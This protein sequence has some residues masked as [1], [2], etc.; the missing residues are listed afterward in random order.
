MQRVFVVDKNRK[1]LMPC[2]SARARTLLKQG[3]A[4][5]LRRYPFTII[6]IEREEGEIQ[7]IQMK[8]DTGAKTTGIALVAVF[9]RGLRCIWAAELEHRGFAVREK[10][11]QRRQI[12]RSRRQRKSR[13]RPSRFL[14]RRRSKGWLAPSL[15]SRLQNVET[16]LKRLASFSPISA[17]VLELTKFDTQLLQNPEISGIV[18]Q[19]GELAGYE[20]REYLLLKWEHHCAYCGIND[21]PLEI[22]HIVPKSRGG[23]NRISNLTLACHNCNQKKGNRT[24]SEFGYPIVHTYASKPLVD[25]A[26]MNTLRWV[27][28]ERLQCFSLPIEIGTGGRTKFNRSRQSYPKSHWIDAA[29]VGTSG[30]AVFVHP[31]QSF[32]HIKA[33]GRQ[34]RQMVLPDRYGFPRTKAKSKSTVQGFRTGDL[35][36]ASV[37]SGKKLGF[38]LGRVAVRS[39]GSFNIGTSEGVVQGISYRYCQC[40]HASDGYTYTKGAGVSSLWQDTGYPSHIQ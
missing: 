32:L 4:A 3:K 25:A 20:I 22:E 13:Y 9:K 35:V 14:N 30:E 36:K 18:Y 33:T 19:Q 24:A 34:S 15:M 1:P 2:H 10:L 11:L 38:H 29:C 26:V 40:I 16:W 17:L 5:I 37:P 23:S 31:K 7:A 12:R 6:L 8:I 28:L 27:M 21:C 39:S